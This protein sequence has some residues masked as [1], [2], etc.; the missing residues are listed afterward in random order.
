MFPRALNQARRCFPLSLATE[1]QLPQ[2]VVIRDHLRHYS[3]AKGKV[4]K[5]KQ[6]LRDDELAEVLKVHV[7]REQLEK[8]LQSLGN[9]YLKQ[10]TITNPVAGLD[11]L[12]VEFENTNVLLSEVC[13]IQKK[14][15]LVVLQFNAFPEAVKPAV[16]VLQNSG[17]SSSI[18]QEGTTVYLH[19]AKVTREQREQMAKSAK[20]L[21]QKTKDQLLQLE[22][23]SS[24]EIQNNKEG[25]SSDLVFH[26]TQ[27]VKYETEQTIEKA[28]GMMKA[29]QK[30]L[31]S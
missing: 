27:Q 16:K 19:L 2:S 6:Q 31:L 23:K 29:K 3:K 4:G 7:F 14:P 5:P 18:Q 9:A 13:Q 30:E 10:L 1:R 11:T 20:A 12:E 28:E 24:K 17:I 8:S 26:A 21:F 25:Q 15:N 22:R